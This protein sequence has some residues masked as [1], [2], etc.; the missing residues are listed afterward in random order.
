MDADEDHEDAAALFEQMLSNLH[1]SL[2]SFQD[3]DRLITDAADAFNLLNDSLL[4]EE[5]D[6]SPIPLAFMKVD[7]I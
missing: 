2:D 5:D 1:V 4:E 7:E 3:E 6:D